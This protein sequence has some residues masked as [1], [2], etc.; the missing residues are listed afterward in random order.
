MRRRQTE[1]S[2]KRLKKTENP[3]LE[4]KKKKKLA[5]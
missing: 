3:V 2:G 1:K 4:A 5:S